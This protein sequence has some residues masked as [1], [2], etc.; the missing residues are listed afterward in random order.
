MSLNGIN[1]AVLSGTD[2]SD[3]LDVISGLDDIELLGATSETRRSQA[4]YEHLVKTRNLVAQ[5]PYLIAQVDYPPAFLK[6]L[7]Y[8]I[9]NWHTS[10]RT[11]ALENL[12]RNENALNRINGMDGVPD[13]TEF[14]G[15]DED[16]AHLEGLSATEIQEELNGKKRKSK[17]PRKKKKGFFRKVG[18]AVKKGVQKGAKAFVRFNP[19]TISARAGFLLAM[20][21]NLKKMASK[22]KWG[23][24]TREQAAAKRISTQQWEKSKKALSKIE[25]LF[26]DKLQGKRSALR[27]AILKGKAG[28]LSGFDDE[29]EVEILGLGIAP[30]AAMAAAVPVIA[31]ALKIMQ[32]AGLMKKGEAQNAETDITTKTADAD[33]TVTDQNNKSSDAETVV[34][35][36]GSDNES[37]SASSTASSNASD[38]SSASN[39]EDRSS[40]EST[41]EETPQDTNSSGEPVTSSTEPVVAEEIQP[42]AS[43]TDNTESEETNP[44]STDSDS[45]SPSN[46]GNE[47]PTDEGVG[48][49]IGF[50]QKQPLL[51]LG[52]VALGI[53]GLSKLFSGGKSSGKG[54]SGTPGRRRKKKK[55]A[56]PKT[57]KQKRKGSRKLKAITLK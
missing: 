40:K 16:W 43:S 17:A 5:K 23:Y 26:A 9:E 15:A 53:W 19:L 52:G 46:E 2:T 54:L 27:N 8:A 50:V 57:K 24:A 4:I 51:A 56:R 38:S 30:A 1:V 7:D 20:K 18:Q 22:L 34:R 47:E 49:I 29:E 42:E 39:D 12:S 3:V 6:M 48:G 36:N 44:E 55:T 13:D 41:P 25:R 11:A 28:G 21:L 31:A 10:N 32:D 37:S 45:G 35:S 14:D 33:L